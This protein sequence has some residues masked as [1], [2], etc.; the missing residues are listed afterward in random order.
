MDS[1]IFET[2]LYNDGISVSRRPASSR[3]GA[4]ASMKAEWSSGN[5]I[6]LP[7]YVG[8][9]ARTKVDVLRYKERGTVPDV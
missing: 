6:R 4:K 1:V 9:W 7:G 8:P 2:R 3:I 5:A